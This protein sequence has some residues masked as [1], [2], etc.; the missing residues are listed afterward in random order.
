MDGDKCP[1]CSSHSRDTT[2]ICITA[3]AREVFS[4][5]STGSFHGLYHVLGG[6]LSPIDGHYPDQ[7]D[8]GR[9]RERLRKNSTK[10][11]ILAF[12]ST[13]EGDATALYLK[14]QLAPLGI[15]LQ[16]LA[17]GLPMGSSLEFIDSGTLKLALQGRQP[18]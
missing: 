11:A 17:L 6:L 2:L 18:L 8:M 16:R 5:E 9:L 10:E 13:L 7:L 15:S 12:D 14:E 4:I 3:T 1:F